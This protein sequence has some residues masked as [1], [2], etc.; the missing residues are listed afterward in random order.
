MLFRSVK[1]KILGQL[2]TTGGQGL[3]IFGALSAA[4][5]GG[6]VLLGAGPEVITG[7]LRMYQIGYTL[8][9]KQTDEQIEQE[10]QGSFT[11]LYASSG[12]TL[13]MGLAS[14]VS[15]G[16]F[17]IPKVKIN[18]TKVSIL[19]RALNEEARIQLLSQIKN[20]GRTAFFTGLRIMAKVFYRSTRK[21]LKQLAL[22]DPNHPLIKLIP[23]GAKSVEQWGSGGEPWSLSLY[24]QNKIENIQANPLT[25]NIG[26]FL[27]NFVEG[28]GEG[29]QEFL[30]DLVRQ[31]MA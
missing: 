29:I 26:V 14:F 28:F 15:G 4:V 6:G 24:V 17:Q 11:S 5:I 31:P 2:N 20:L 10:I 23:G 19:W 16:V 21:M 1:N 9:L 18:M 7:M 3:A 25:K 30:P 27:E 13:G 8:N 22:T 12:E